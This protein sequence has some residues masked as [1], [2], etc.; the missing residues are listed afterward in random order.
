MDK[1]IG[2]RIG[3]LVVLIAMAVIS[4][5]PC[6]HDY[7]KYA[8]GVVGDTANKYSGY[9]NFLP[10]FFCAFSVA[11]MILLFIGNKKWPRVIGIFLT[12]AKLAFPFLYYGLDF[13]EKVVGDLALNTADFTIY[14]PAVLGY[15]LLG[16]G[17]LT[18]ILY[19]VD[20]SND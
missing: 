20:M 12:I 7:A 2:M 17:V 3:I 14:K 9:C 4:F 18:I 6:L 8:I 11:E 15:V 19:C 10:Q 13:K 16:L 1:K 5:G